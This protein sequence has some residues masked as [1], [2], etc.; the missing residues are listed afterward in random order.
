[1]EVWKDIPDY[2]GIY[3]ASNTGLIRSTPNKTTSNKRF[4]K[5]V[6]KTRILKHKHPVQRKRQD[7]RVTLWKD[8]KSRDYLVSRLIAITWVDGYSPELTVNH[9]DGNPN[10]NACANLEWV[11]RSENITKGF[12]TGLYASVQKPIELKN[13]DGVFV[14]ASMAEASRFLG[15]NHGYIH[16]CLRRNTAA[17]DTCGNQY[18]INLKKAVLI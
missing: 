3:Q 13:A 7:P 4:D 14:F 16:N 2:E 5:R 9:I 15:R 18:E 6:W 17:K 11:T 12:E 8:G 10:N 1:M